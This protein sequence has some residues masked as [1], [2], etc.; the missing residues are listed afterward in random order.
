MQLEGSQD[1][2]QTEPRRACGPTLATRRGPNKECELSASMPFR[3]GGTTPGNGGRMLKGVSSKRGEDGTRGCQLW[4][5]HWTRGS[6][7]RHC[8]GGWILTVEP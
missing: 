3:G 4:L 2:N 7:R 6:V 8:Q 1:T 5:L